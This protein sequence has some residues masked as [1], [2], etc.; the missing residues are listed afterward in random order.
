MFSNPHAVETLLVDGHRELFFHPVVE[1]QTC[2]KWQNTRTIFLSFL[3]WNILFTTLLSL[4][5]ILDHSHHQAIKTVSD[6]FYPSSIVIMLVLSII[7]YVPIIIIDITSV[8]TTNRKLVSKPKILLQSLHLLLFLSM[9]M[10][11]PYS[12][13]ISYSPAVVRLHSHLSAWTLL[14]AWTK[15]IIIIQDIP[16]ITVYVQIFLNVFCDILKYLLVMF[17]LLIGFCL[18]FHII[19]PY[20]TEDNQRF[21]SPTNSFF[22][23][24]SMLKGEIS[25]DST[26][27][28]SILEV[29]G[30]TQLIFLLFFLTINIVMIN[31]LIGLTITT[32]QD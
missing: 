3:T 28:E 13:H 22:K 23:M 24:I 17:S 9:T 10:T 29:E 25:Y 12:E 1:A 27:T 8:F 2:L 16:A 6:K 18:S 11:R 19:L 15:N 5:V 20:N 7:F 26:F 31:I 21:K 32:A 14:M 4:L 30:T